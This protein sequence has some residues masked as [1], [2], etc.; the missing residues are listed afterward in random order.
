MLWGAMCEKEACKYVDE[1][2]TWWYC[3]VNIS[4]DTIR[5]D[6]CSTFLDSPLVA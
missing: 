4:V 2:D 1:I 5:Y 6:R 3:A